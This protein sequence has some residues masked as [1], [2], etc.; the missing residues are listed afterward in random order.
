MDPPPTETSAPVQLTAGKR[1]AIYAVYKEGGGG[2]YC[3]VAWREVGDPA[4]PRTLPYISGD[5][6]STYAQPTTFTP[7]TVAITSPADGATFETNAV[8]TLTATAAPAAGK[9]IVRVEFLEETKILGDATAPP[10]TITIA[11]LSE[12]PHKITV[13]VVDS[14]YIS[15]V[16]APV[17]VNVGKQSLVVDLA[18]I[19]DITTW[20]YDRSGTDMGTAWRE[21]D[22]NDS[23]WPQGKALIADEGTTTVAPIRTGISRFNDANEYVKTFYFR[24]KFNFNW[25]VNNG[26]KLQLRHVVDD[27]AIFYLNGREIHRFNVAAD[28]VDYLSDAT[29][30]EN[31]W[32][33]PYDI[34]IDAL[35]TGENL[36]AAEV[37]QSGGGSS[38]MVFGGELVAIVLVQDT[39]EVTPPPPGKPEFTKVARE[40]ND[41]LLEYKDGVLQGSA[42]ATGGYQ[43][44]LGAGATSHRVSTSAA[45][46]Q[47]FRLRSP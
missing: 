44:V 31:A 10:Y 21:K 18:L 25:E 7:P 33:G 3:D 5:V 36:L 41:L 17:Q 14:A 29:G 6:L 42:T 16:S 43:D 28:P 34:P 23:A 30:H 2:D 27:G 15:T 39:G 11:G 22:F 4:I 47:Y 8:I 20:R 19:D 38:D 46:A 37:H 40:G 32:E 26:V 24:L 35:T 45:P 9:N 13:R 12:G 1:Y